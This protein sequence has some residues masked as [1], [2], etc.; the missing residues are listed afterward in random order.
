[1]VVV[2]PDG[3]P[4][5]ALTAT[6]SK[7]WRSMRRN[8]G[9]S[10]LEGIGRSTLA[11]SR[12][13]RQSPLGQIVRNGSSPELVAMLGADHAGQAFHLTL[14]H[15]RRHHGISG[16]PLGA[17][18]LGR[19]SARAKWC[20][21]SRP[22]PVRRVAVVVQ[23]PPPAPSDVSPLR[24]LI[25]EVAGPEV[26]LL[27]Y[28]SAEAHERVRRARVGF[29]ARGHVPEPPQLAAVVRNAFGA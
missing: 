27:P 14:V 20:R 18:A 1:M 21:R 23:R 24:H 22:L 29:E 15:P 5:Q 12:P 4:E 6:S 10:A 13:V 9:R 19:N 8:T 11:R 3:Q 2:G 25:E 7:I 28:R 26:R 17:C 16:A